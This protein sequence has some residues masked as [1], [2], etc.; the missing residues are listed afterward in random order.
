MDSFQK[1]GN[2]V[3]GLR[4]DVDT[5]YG[6]KRGVPL[7]LDLLSD[8]SVKASFFVPMGPDRTGRNFFHA[9]KR[10]KQHRGVNPFKK[11]GLKNSLYGFLLPSPN[12]YESGLK[13]LKEAFFKGHEVALHG[14]DHYKWAN[15]LNK[16]TFEEVKQDV[17]KGIEAYMKTFRKKPLGF[18]SPAFSWNEKSLTVLEGEGFKYSS[19]FKG[20]QFLKPFYP[21]IQGKKHRLMQIPINQPLIEDLEVL[22]LSE[23]KNL[24]TFLKKLNSLLKQK[25]NNVFTMYI[26]ACY[27]PFHKRKILEKIL[28]K[29]VK[30]EDNIHVK[31]FR[32]IAKTFEKHKISNLR[33]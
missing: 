2:I 16:M 13:E 8:F 5:I 21:K 22:G 31:Q 14:F 6:L 1:R 10:I 7:L 15:Y 11:F 30:N 26:H 4:V 19:D 24:Q 25:N 9:L 29:I 12:F 3:F 20:K 33:L 28:E 17:L 32:E 23:E 27:E 18:A